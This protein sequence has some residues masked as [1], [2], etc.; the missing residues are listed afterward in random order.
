MNFPYKIPQKPH[1]HGMIAG[2]FISAATII[3]ECEPHQQWFGSNEQVMPLLKLTVYGAMSAAILMLQAG[4]KALAPFAL[5][6]GSVASYTIFSTLLNVQAAAFLTGFVLWTN[7]VGLLSKEH[8]IVSEEAKLGKENLL[9]IASAAILFT[10]GFFIHNCHSPAVW[11]VP[12]VELALNL[13]GMATAQLTDLW[14]KP[15]GQK[16]KQQLTAAPA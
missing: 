11:P 5:T 13:A 6:S 8:G 3:S 15:L 9:P 7:A 10:T 14:Q 16:I 1:I 4:M 2:Y 12:S